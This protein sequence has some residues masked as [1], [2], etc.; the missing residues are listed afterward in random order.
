MTRA[1]DLVVADPVLGYGDP[2]YVASLVHQ[3]TPL[4]LP[5]S[6]AWLLERPIEGCGL[7]DAVGPYPLLTCRDADAFAADLDELA[8]GLVSVTAVVDPMGD[9]TSEQI[10]RA[11][12]DVVRPFKEHF[13][14]DLSR[15]VEE[16]ATKHHRRDAR[17]GLRRVTIEA[18]VEPRAWLD[19]WVGLYDG[20]IER[21]DIEGPSR[22]PRES[23]ERLAQ[24]PGLVA[25]RASIAGR[26]VGMQLWLLRGPVA[27]YHLAATNAEGYDEGAA[28]A[29]MWHALEDLSARGVVAL[30]HMGAGLEADA[31]DGL[32]HFKR[33]WSTSTRTAWMGGR[34]LDRSAY[35]RLCKER[36]EGVSFFPAY[37]APRG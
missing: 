29:L 27:A 36:E 19:D 9:W 22:F 20:L 8:D 4:Q 16:V 1:G 10:A 33:G 23:F 18:N 24:V 6:G 35:D 13:V 12:P 21:H 2:A 11:F 32:T 28:Y 14:T 34:V 30:A 26:T 37:R 7:R 25:H 15:P 3:G 5:R 17:R 31:A